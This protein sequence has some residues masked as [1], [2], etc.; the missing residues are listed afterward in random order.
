MR[1]TNSRSHDK[2]D[3]F[4][5]RSPFACAHSMSQDDIVGMLDAA[6]TGMCCDGQA[7]RGFGECEERKTVR[8]PA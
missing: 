3:H 7:G 5:V 2:R 8:L 1:R 4:W 6:L